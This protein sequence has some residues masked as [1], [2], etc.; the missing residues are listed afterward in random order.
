LGAVQGLC[1]PAK[2]PETTVHSAAGALAV[3]FGPEALVTIAH[4]SAVLIEI[5]MGVCRTCL[6]VLRIL[7]I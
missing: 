1:A 4:A 7:G 5:L 2:H 6:P 3:V